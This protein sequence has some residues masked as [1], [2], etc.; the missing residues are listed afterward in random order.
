MILGIDPG[1]ANPAY[2]VLNP[3]LDKARVQVVALGMIETRATDTIEERLESLRISM[4]KLLSKHPVMLVAIEMYFA[5]QRQVKLKRGGF[6]MAHDQNAANMHYATAAFMMPCASE[7][8][9]I[10]MVGPRAMKLRI[11][12]RDKADKDMI[13]DSIFEISDHG[14]LWFDHDFLEPKEMLNT[15]H[16]RDACGMA[17]YSL[18]K[19][20]F[21]KLLDYRR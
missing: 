12:G 9:P 5:Q 15:D 21:N 4:A 11:T 17:L 8:V 20:R 13:R 6:R 1:I 2:V 19:A 7:A 14:G 3:N 10:K 16:L 18:S